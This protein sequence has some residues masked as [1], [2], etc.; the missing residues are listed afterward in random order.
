ML[1]SVKSIISSIIINK[2]LTKQ[3]VKREIKGRYKGSYL[4]LLWSFITPIF[5]LI[6]YTF[7]F[8]VIFQAKWGNNADTNKLEFAL[9]L[10]SGLLVFNVFAEIISRAPSIITSNANY[11][12]K[13]V[14][15]LEILPIV[16][17]GSAL[18]HAFIS[19]IVL[20]LSMFLLIGTLHWTIILFP[21]VLLP[22]CLISLGLSWFLASLG[23]YI[24]DIGQVINIIVSALMFLSPIF[25]P[26]SA[27]PKEM[28]FL[29]YFNP[30]SYAVEDTRRTIIW[31]QL[32]HW[33]W[34]GYGML[35]GIVVAL[36]GY[37]WFKKTRKGFA[38]VL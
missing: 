17:L 13:V 14:F 8:S 24:R 6:I 28:Q 19:L 25:Y 27:I 37:I 9:L 10:F 11:V 29:Y 1:G 32:P 15:P 4:G 3:L 26:I 16:S 38:D 30:I 35:V 12:K 18:F 34:L 7:V 2:S 23:V 22:I 31:G 36:F 5:M 20:I 33:N 21:L